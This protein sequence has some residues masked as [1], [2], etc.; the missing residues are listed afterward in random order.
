M[1]QISENLYAIFTRG[2]YVNFFVI[3]NG[4][5]LTVV[6]IALGKEDVDR[7]ERELGEKSWSIEQ[8]KHILITHA[9]PD[10]IGG[11]PELQ[12]RSNAHTYIH[13]LDAPVVRGEKAF[14]HANPEELGFFSRLMLPMMRATTITP[15]RVDTDLNGDETLDDILPGLEVIHLP[16]HSYGHS[17]FWLSSEKIL[18]GGDVLMNLP[19]GLRYPLRAPSP[20]WNA[21]KNSIRKVAEL[22]PKILGLAHGAVV[23]G[24]IQAKI[25]RLLAN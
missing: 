1:R 23:S 16:G 9:H 2:Q 24:D 6:D 17:G 22:N 12:K 15:A 18:I 11:L 14:P 5:T 13:R 8:V 20:D 25:K 7:L 19:W 10:H 21:V 3:A 4:E